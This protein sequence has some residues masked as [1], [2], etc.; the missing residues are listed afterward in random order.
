MIMVKRLYAFRFM[1][2]SLSSLVDNL[3]GINNKTENNFVDHMRSMIT[4]LPVC[5]DKISH[6]DQKYR[7][8]YHKKRT[9]K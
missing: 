6:I 4:S 3:S 5:I 7:K 9:R 1:Q 8:K 2:D